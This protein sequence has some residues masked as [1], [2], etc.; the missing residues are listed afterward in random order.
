MAEQK[1]NVFR[2][3]SLDSISSPEQLQDYLRVTNP[4]M[5]ML[6]AAVISLLAG[7][8]A[9][10]MVGELETLADGAAVVDHGQAVILVADADKGSIASGMTFRIGE[11]EYS[12]SAVET[13]ESGRTVA[14]APVSEADGKY[15]VK[16]VTERIHPIEFLFS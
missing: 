12:I 10:S 4:G 1:S 13:D 16:I 11:D 9:W 14:Y 7:L 3:Q 8:F 2:Q 5:W 6:L 15:D